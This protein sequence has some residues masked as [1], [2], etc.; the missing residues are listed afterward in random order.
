LT[1]PS[2]LNGGGC[3]IAQTWIVLH[4][5][6]KHDLSPSPEIANNLQNVEDLEVGVHFFIHLHKNAII[7][8]VPW[9]VI[10]SFNSN[11]ESPARIGNS[12]FDMSAYLLNIKYAT[13]MCGS[14]LLITLLHTGKLC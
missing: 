4:T 1:P 11:L 13:V 2:L 12:L 7:E 3:D 14:S 8:S 5:K 10:N 9:W 6:Q